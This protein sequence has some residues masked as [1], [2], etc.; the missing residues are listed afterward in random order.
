[1]LHW[2]SQ[3]CSWALTLVGAR[4]WEMSRQASKGNQVVVTAVKIRQQNVVDG[5]GGP[6]YIRTAGER[7]LRR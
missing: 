3:A 7:V 5:G 2:A 4:Q 6:H 1:M